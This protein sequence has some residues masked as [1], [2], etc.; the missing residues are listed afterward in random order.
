MTNPE[1]FSEDMIKDVETVI[2]WNSVDELD[3]GKDF[4]QKVESMKQA[5][6]SKG[7]DTGRIPIPW[8]RSTSSY[9]GFT[10]RNGA[11]P[12]LPPDPNQPEA[13]V[14]RQLE[15]TDSVWAFYCKM[16][17]LRK[18]HKALVSIKSHAR[19]D[20]SLKAYRSTVSMRSWTQTTRTS[21]HILANTET[22]RIS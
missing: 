2:Y 12:W 18:F 17:R 15:N 9:G 1:E 7:R 11:E 13:C 19:L 20:L 16:I 6:V 10:S 3:P 8:T 5:I 22:R 21:S 4:D 14:E